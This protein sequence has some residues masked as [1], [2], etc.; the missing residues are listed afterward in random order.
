MLFLQVAAGKDCEPL[1]DV[2]R[3][4]L[5]LSIAASRRLLPSSAAAS[6]Q[7]VQT[8]CIVQPRVLC[9]AVPRWQTPMGLRSA[10][11]VA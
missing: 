6:H 1:R 8:V 11:W 5:E 4:E 10:S 9:L 2:D 3:F 7:P